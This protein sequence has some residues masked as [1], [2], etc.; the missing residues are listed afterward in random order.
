[1]NSDFRSCI[2]IEENMHINVTAI[3]SYGVVVFLPGLLIRNGKLGLETTR[4]G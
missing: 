2:T 3:Y 1:M 4:E